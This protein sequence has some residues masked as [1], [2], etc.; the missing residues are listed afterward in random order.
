VNVKK[1]G[2]SQTQMGYRT[3]W[4]AMHEL[5][6]SEYGMNGLQGPVGD[7]IHLVISFEAVKQ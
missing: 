4:E 2:E 3:G 6:R 7:D 1:T 5:K